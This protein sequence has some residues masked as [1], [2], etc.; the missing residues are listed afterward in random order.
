METP[1]KNS[2]RGTYRTLRECLTDSE[3]LAAQRRMEQIQKNYLKRR[4]EDDIEPV[5]WDEL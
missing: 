1:K 3:Y 5:D 2:A 4:L